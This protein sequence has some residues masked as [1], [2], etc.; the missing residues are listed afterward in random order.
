LLVLSEADYP[1]WRA[2]IDGQP[3]AIRRVDHALRG[4]AVPAGDHDVELRY[5]PRSFQV[6]M[7]LTLLAL[8]VLA[9]AGRRA[10]WPSLS[11]VALLPAIWMAVAAAGPRDPDPPRAEPAGQPAP[12]RDDVVE[13]A[14]LPDG[15]KALAAGFGPAESWSMGRAGRWTEGDAVLH[16]ARPH[17]ESGLAVDMTL[18]RPSGETAGRIEVRGRTLRSFRAPNGRRREVVDLSGIPAGDVEMRVVTEDPIAVPGAGTGRARGVF[19]H[20]VS[21][22]PFALAAEVEPGSV[23]DAR[24]ELVSGWWGA[25]ARPGGPGGRW[26]GPLA[27]LDLVRAADEDGLFLDVTFDHPTGVTTGRIEVAGGPARFIRARNGRETLALDIGAVAGRT[28]AV[29]LLADRPFVPRQYDPSAGDGR[30]LG[31]FVHTARLGRKAPCP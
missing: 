8:I 23:E 17:G 20:S 31:F 1:G 16:I 4:L 21:L 2:T 7:T 18:D 30:A 19:L 26:T 6:G 25:E 24:P 14:A 11:V 29:R 9:V 27:V 10:A 15:A 22:L 5:R 28:I 13:L 12:E 3:A